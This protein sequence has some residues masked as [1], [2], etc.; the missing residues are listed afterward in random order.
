M[1][2][3]TLALRMLRK[4]PF[5]TAVA[6]LS[7]ALGIGANAA[8]FSL[9]DQLLLRTLPVRDAQELVNFASPGP[10]PGS[11]SCNQQGECSEAFSY[12]MYRDLEAKQTALV[13]VAAS[14]IFGASLS[15]DNEP[16]VG[17]G[18]WVSGTYFSTLGVQPLLG[19]LLGP[20][21]DR[22]PDGHDLVVIS[23]SLWRDRFAARTDVVG[24]TMV[25]NGRTMEIIGVLPE[26]FTGA[27]A[28]SRP[29]LYIPL[30]MR[31]AFSTTGYRGYENRRDYSLYVFGRLK[32]GGTIE[33]AEAA[34]NTLYQPILTEVEAPLQEGMSESTLERFKARRIELAPGARGQSRVH[35]E[36]QTP[37][38]LLFAITG[39]VLLIACANVANLLLARGAGRSTEMGVRLALGAS[40]GTL[41]RQL[42]L[43]S[44]LLAALGGVASL[45]V[46]RWTLTGI[47]TLLPPDAVASMNFAVDWQVM[48]FA[49]V[50]AVVTGFVFGLY[51]ALQS[52]RP[53]LIAAIRAGAGQIVG[54][55]T[56]A[57]LRAALVTVQI[58]LSMAL[59]ASA[60]LFVKSLSQVSKVNLGIVTEDVITFST[61]PSRVGYDT[62][63]AGVF[64]RRLEEELKSLPGVTGVTS[65]M[66]GLL[67]GNDWGNDVRVQGFECGPDTDCNSVYS[68]VG[69]GFFTTMG[70]QMLAGR[71]F[72]ESDIA[73][74]TQVAVVNQ[75]FAEKF[76]LGNDAVGKF[77]GRGGQNA[78]SLQIL[79]V[80]LVPNIAY[81]NVRQEEPLPVF[82]IPWRQNTRT[83]YMN[84][85]VRSSL[86]PEQM[87]TQIPALVKRLDASL[88]VEDLKTMPQQIRE[89]V[90]FDRMISILASAFAVLATLLAAV[91]LYGVMAYSVSQRTREIGVRM[92]LGADAESVQ[93][94]VLRQVLWMLGIGGVIGLGAAFALGRAAQSLLF[95]IRPHDPMALGI[96]VALLSVVALG[97]GYLPARRASR[98]DPMQALRYD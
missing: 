77:M 54:G 91:G 4:T 80:G 36:A 1:R 67:A 47:A 14:R 5:V 56:S 24:K 8:I 23:H 9:F 6:V 75:R 46:A 73:G 84:W 89:N 58:A 10:K 39:T 27:T 53:D 82:Y 17:E 70:A 71:D 2:Q 30:S 15:I 68:E 66:V 79:I 48:L 11:T 92:A 34:L 76:G 49:G 90:F 65:S 43:E 78:D 18:A 61:S 13:S 52:T 51:P 45:L 38:M 97:A 94:L 22:V 59:L 86:P 35:A 32:P 50:L 83:S 29:L 41:L 57:K 44:L 55:H 98:V 28:G 19:R 21:D 88:P 60:S 69:P 12:P 31:W 81:N 40:R 95:E 42:M 3:L 25:V 87:L 93:R 96:S 37:L 63:R 26:Q 16:S 33:E 74:A 62:L 85:Y 64:N 7:L 20:D 72:T